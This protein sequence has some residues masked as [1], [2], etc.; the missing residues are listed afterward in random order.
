M[1]LGRRG[2]ESE[3]RLYLDP[4]TWLPVG[5]QRTESHYFLGQVQAEYIYS[6]WEKTADIMYPVSV[7]RLTDG[8]IERSRTVLPGAPREIKVQGDMAVSINPL[9]ANAVAPDGRILVQVVSRASWFWPAAII[10]PGT[11]RSASYHPDWPTTW[12]DLDGT[13][14]RAW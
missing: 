2:A 4:A 9:V 10:D 1:V 14:T 11:G 8:A 5:V 7:T 12:G 6:T 13:P 3:E